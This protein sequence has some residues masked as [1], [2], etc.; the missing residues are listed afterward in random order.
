VFFIFII[1][2][3]I[4]V[5]GCNN[6]N[7]ASISFNNI[8]F[9]GK[10]NTVSAFGRSKLEIFNSFQKHRRKK[11][12]LRKNSNFYAKSILIFGAALSQITVDT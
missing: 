8:L 10:V 3:V 5:L 7:V 4:T 1:M 2:S 6:C 9:D 11:E 12:K